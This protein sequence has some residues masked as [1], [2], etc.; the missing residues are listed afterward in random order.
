MLEDKPNWATCI[1]CSLREFQKDQGI[2]CSLHHQKPNFDRV[3]PYFEKQEKSTSFRIKHQRISKAEREGQTRVA[4]S[5]MSSY[6]LVKSLSSGPSRRL[7]IYGWIFCFA[8]ILAS[9]ILGFPISLVA[10]AFVF[11]FS[12][13]LL[14]DFFSSK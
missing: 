8:W 9:V 12:L 1:Q 14:L 3:C 4:G 2:V 6:G 7:I 10:V 13:L 5:M 11:V